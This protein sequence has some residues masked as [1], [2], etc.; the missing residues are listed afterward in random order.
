MEYRDIIYNNYMSVGFGTTK[1][2][3]S[4]KNNKRLNKY[5][6]KNYLPFFKSKKNPNICDLGCGMGHFLELCKINGY[7]NI[8]GV[9]GSPENIKFC[10]ESGYNVIQSDIFEFLSNNCNSFDIIIFNDVIE[11]L[12]K[13]EIVTILAKL[14]QALKSG[15]I[16]LIKTPNMSNPLVASSGRYIDFTH[17]T[18][19]TEYS[20]RQVLRATGFHK[21]LIRG[22]DIY[23]MNNPINLIAKI[24]SKSINLIFWLLSSLYGR[25][26]IHIFEKDILAIG[27]KTD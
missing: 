18:G 19:F 16:V 23:V 26:S 9:D 13:N 10:K 14:Y 1:R 12:T 27:Y 25:T 11:H 6:Q 4:L 5:F 3:Q 15:G 8:I 24:I 21:I 2:I 20:M 22:T 7:R 17:E